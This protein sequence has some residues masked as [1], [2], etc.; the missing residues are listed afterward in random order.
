MKSISE[1]NKEQAIMITKLDTDTKNKIKKSKEQTNDRNFP[2][3]DYASKLKY[4]KAV[5][6]TRELDDMEL[7]DDTNAVNLHNN[8]M[9]Y[10]EAFTNN[11]K[12]KQPRE[13]T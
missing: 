2:K 3:L 1:I 12:Q 6:P 8:Y 13:K 7:S 10:A 11:H 4:V 5:H 9:N